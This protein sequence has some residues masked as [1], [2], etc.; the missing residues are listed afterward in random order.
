MIFN[1]HQRQI[2]VP[3]GSL[4]ACWLQIQ[5]SLPDPWKWIWVLKLFLLCCW[6]DVRGLLVGGRW[7]DSAGGRGFFS[8]FLCLLF[9][10]FLLLLFGCDQWVGWGRHPVALASSKF[11]QSFMDS[12]PSSFHSPPERC[13]L[14]VRSG[15]G[16][17]PTCTLEQHL[18]LVQPLLMGSGLERLS[19]LLCQPRLREGC[20][21]LE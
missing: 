14:L 21:F 11:Q 18:L 20:P 1:S 10:F 8:Q 13:F 15:H 2:V 19:T 4:F 16:F 5:T 17:L 9:F 3:V 12:V 7:R 6:H